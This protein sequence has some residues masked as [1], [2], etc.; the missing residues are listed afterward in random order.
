MNNTSY[1]NIISRFRKVSRRYFIIGIAESS[2]YAFT[3]L[4]SLM[5]ISALCESVLFMAPE[6]KK[7]LFFSTLIIP[8]VVFA[9]LL[10]ICFIRRPGH[11]EISRII[12]RFYPQLGD[13]LISSVQ[14]GSL[15]EDNLKGQSKELINAL[16]KKVEEETRF[17]KIEKSA[18]AGRLFLSLKVASATLMLFLLLAVLLPEYLMGGFYRLADYKKLYSAPDEM[19]IYVMPHKNSIIRGDNFTASGFISGRKSEQLKILFRWDD[20][21]VWN[22][23]PIDVN[24]KT[25]N[26]TITVE[27]PRISLQYYLETDSAVTNQSRVTVIERPVVEVLEITLIYPEYTGFGTVSR[28]DNDG[29]IRAL[30]GTGVSLT[31]KA[32]KLLENMSLF[33]SDSIVTRCKVEG[34]TGTALFEVAES[35][36]Y[37]IGLIDTLGIANNN[38]IKYRVTVMQDEIPSVSI[39]SPA[40]DITLP[41]SMTFPI[42]YR[43]DD[44]YGLSSVS[45]KFKLPFEENPRVIALHKGRLDKNIESEYVWNMTGMNLLP[46]DSIPFNIIVYDNDTLSGPK[47]GISETRTVRLP[48]IT[49]I[50]NNVL[51]EQDEGIDKLKEISERSFLQEKELE[52]IN[53]TIKSGKE[54]EWSDKNALDEAKKNMESMQKEIKDISNTIQNVADKLSAENIVTLETLEKLQKISEIMDNI[55]EGEMKEA[56]KLLTRA[57]LHFNPRE[58]KQS[59]DRYKITTED[60][61][62]KLDRIINLLE[63]VKSIQHYEM[64]KSLL[65][66]MAVKQA[67][68][69]NKYRLD[70]DNSML[71]IEEEKLGNEMGK[72]QDELKEVARDLKERFKINTD[73]LKNYVESHN[74]AEKKKQASQQMSDGSVEEAT[75]SLDESNIMISELLEQV[76]G[77]GAVMQA[78]NTEELKRRLFK[79]LNDMLVVS[80]KQER[81][82]NEIKDFDNEELAQKQL[83][84]IDAHSTAEKSLVRFGEISID[85]SG[86]IDQLTASTR[87]VMENTV[88]TFAKGNIKGGEKNAQDALKI[89]NN[90]IHFLSMLLQKG[91]EISGMPGDLMQ[92]L[93]NIANGQLSL[94][95]QLSL[96]QMQQLAAEQ[97]RLAEMLSELSKNIL[98]DKRLREI[99]EKLA[100]EMDDTAYMMHRNEKRELVEHKQLDIYRRLLDARRSRRQKDESEVRKSWTAKKNISIGAEKLADNLGEKENELNERIK[101]AMNDDFDPEYIKLIR[102]YFESLL[103]GK[104]GVVQ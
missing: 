22:M 47:M 94:Q 99:L 54:L 67:E 63:Q 41:A 28:N 89:L 82:L 26:F 93:Q 31:V 17:L 92:Q 53:R 55:A 74:I 4:V 7:S 104:S 16:L 5:G 45:L 48:S 95:Q 25:G 66:D 30:I 73:N 75:S 9:A 61:K 88:D 29:N 52:D 71:S 56:L 12:E 97:Q 100:E 76:D 81:F 60:I 19:N 77:V 68:M 42:L 79:S 44:D 90:N 40:S 98:E 59:L 69:A 80:N 49:D 87:M 15:T 18:P 23:K 46:D 85:L 83:D 33:W 62:N 103:Q 27:K 84:I 64:T 8:V 36:D 72:I 3:A 24:E 78:A 91:P 10:V 14:L 38:P 43:A 51:D 65:E 1:T 96:E 32:N 6:I 58:V 70:P 21:S 39:L 86:L 20:S 102:Q 11:D 35:A 50:F 101:K 57:N 13:R 34:D 37:H 2:G